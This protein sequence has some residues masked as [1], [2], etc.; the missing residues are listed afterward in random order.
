MG[1]SI[2]SYRNQAIHDGIPRPTTGPPRRGRLQF[3]NGYATQRQHLPHGANILAEFR[4]DYLGSTPL[5]AATTPIPLEDDEQPLP[6]LHRAKQARASEPLNAAWATAAVR[7]DTSP[8]NSS[9]AGKL[10]EEVAAQL[11]ALLAATDGGC[12]LKL[13]GPV[14]AGEGALRVQQACTVA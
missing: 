14:R 12:Q 11:L 7:R 8:A 6:R 4:L 2:R 10:D 13:E 1:A 9:F 3:H 5:P